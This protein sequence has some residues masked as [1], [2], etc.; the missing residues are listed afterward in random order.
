MDK[1][2]TVGVQS[3]NVIFSFKTD[4]EGT[5]LREGFEIVNRL[6]SSNKDLLRKATRDL[7]SPI[8]R[9][10]EPRAIS[11]SELAIPAPEKESLLA[12][13]DDMN[14]FELLLLLL[15][16]AKRKITNEQIMSLSTELGKPIKYNWL[17]SETHRP[18]RKGLIMSEPIPGKQQRLYSLTE[19]GKKKAEAIVHT[20]N[21]KKESE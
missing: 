7:P 1:E 16:Y 21:S 17:D 8:V 6:I 11:I 5:N 19:R 12:K 2:I 13:I 3:G 9:V 4:E 15:H 10:E 14:R 18:E 20:I